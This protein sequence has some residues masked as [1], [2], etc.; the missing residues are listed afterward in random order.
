MVKLENVFVL[1]DE[2]VVLNNFSFTF[3]DKGVVLITG[4][5]GKGKTTLV[6]VL[7]GIIKPDIGEV[8][9]DNK[10]ISVVF[11]E[12]R[13]IPT[14]TALQNV[15]LVSD[16]LSAT[17]RLEQMRL[18]D[19]GDKYPSELS[20]GMKRRVAIARALSFGGDI[21]ILDEA[22][23][24]IEDSLAEDIIKEISEEYCEKLIIAVTHR[25]ELFSQANPIICS[26]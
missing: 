16:K 8:D 14:L 22:F 19:S 6:R 5:S 7:L 11:Q 17:K 25:P 9:I 20:G 21:L 23:S 1:F 2:K 3:P 18:C 10:K 24:G 4:P 13:L 15:E 12:D 26:I